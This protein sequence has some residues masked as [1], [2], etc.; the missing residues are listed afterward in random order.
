MQIKNIPNYN[1]LDEAVKAVFSENVKIVSKSSISGGDINRAYALSLSNGETVFMKA[2]SIKNA[3]FFTAEALGLFALSSVGVIGVPK[4]LCTGIG[5]NDGIS[6]LL[7]EM[8]K[9]GTRRKKDYWELLGHELASLHKAGCSVFADDKKYG[10]LS[11]NYIGM[12]PQKNTPCTSWIEFYSENRLKV[13]FKRAESYFDAP[14]LKRIQ[15]LLDNLDR[16]L[17]EPE[18]PSLLHG[19]LWSGNVITGNDG[20]AWI[21]DPAVYVGHRE[22]DLAMT[23]L[24]GGFPCGF[25]ASYNETAPIENGYDTRRE[26]YNLYQLLNHLNMFGG[27]YLSSVLRILR[28][29]T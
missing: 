9:A 18:Y 27:S 23:E 21:I 17:I 28:T 20:K 8:L 19:D 15:S 24:F 6:F 14:D 3:S 11:D 7:L 16:L 10:F 5:K 22:V 13:Q 12:S 1:S 4:I 29:F 2:N 26:L 25:Y